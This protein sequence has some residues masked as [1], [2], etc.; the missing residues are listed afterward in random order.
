MNENTVS[1]HLKETDVIAI[2]ALLG[3]CMS[4]SLLDDLG[5]STLYSELEDHFDDQDV[6]NINGMLTRAASDI[7]CAV[8]P[9]RSP[10]HTVIELI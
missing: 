1:L 5:L 4:G 9:R 6:V 3:H 2:Y 10:R 8:I 7:Q